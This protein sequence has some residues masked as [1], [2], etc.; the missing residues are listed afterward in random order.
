[1]VQSLSLST[2]A[3]CG[4]I[5]NQKIPSWMTPFEPFK[6]SQISSFSG[7]HLVCWNHSV[8]SFF[9]IG[10]P[11]VSR[12]G[13]FK[14]K[15]AWMFRGG[16]QGLDASSEHSESANEDILMFFFQLD[17]ATRV[18][19]LLLLLLCKKLS[20]VGVISNLWIFNA[21]FLW[22][23]WISVCFEYGAV[24]SCTATEKQTYW[25]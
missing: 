3:T 17:L 4:K 20:G 16:E 14:A 18:Q 10:Y 6:R 8:H 19:V 9:L 11:Y 22:N 21:S 15:A 2:L 25:G 12:H 23:F 7:K 24:W 1:M 13:G 5:P